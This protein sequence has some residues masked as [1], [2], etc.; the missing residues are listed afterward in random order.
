MNVPAAI[1]CVL[2]REDALSQDCL[3]EGP[4]VSLHIQCRFGTCLHIRN[5][6]PKCKL[7][8]QVQENIFELD[9][10]HAVSLQVLK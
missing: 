5:S 2:V 7:K 3:R 1:I 8:M 6:S 4:R 9:T 10:I